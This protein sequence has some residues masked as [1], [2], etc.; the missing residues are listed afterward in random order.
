MQDLVEKMKV[1]FMN[2]SNGTKKASRWK[3]ELLYENRKVLIGSNKKSLLS[4][5]KGNKKLTI[6]GKK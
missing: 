1:K 4:A 2:I 5:R 3:Q 6:I